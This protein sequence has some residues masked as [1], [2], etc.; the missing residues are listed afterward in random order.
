MACAIASARFRACKTSLLNAVL[1]HLLSA[2]PSAQSSAVRAAVVPSFPTEARTSPTQRLRS[3]SSADA[4][5]PQGAADAN[6][7]DAAA[8]L[9]VTPI[10]L[11]DAWVEGFYGTSARGVNVYSN[12]STPGAPNGYYTT[13]ADDSG[14]LVFANVSDCSSFSDQ[15]M[16]R[17]YGWMPATTSPRPLAE[18][19]YWTIRNDVG[20]AE[21]TNVNDIA[22][23]DV[24]A[25]LYPP[26]GASDTGHVAWIDALPVAFSGSPVESGLLQFVVTV[27]DSTNGFHDNVGGPSTKTDDRYLGNLT[28]GTQCTTD[29][30]CLTLYGSNAACNSES[31]INYSVCSYTGVGRGQMRLYADASG[32]IQG[33]TWSPNEESTYYARPNPL[34]T[35]GGS[36]TGEDIVVGHF[37]R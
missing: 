18:D 9:P 35:Q 1:S 20:F 33:H 32:A 37:H 2:L 17:S 29:T 23:G 27:I 7:P 34:P 15:L 8:A 25:L 5:S 21:V 16:Q 30:Q 3:A 4:S 19:Y 6:P 26:G 11:A 13:W 31:L 22:V 24:I 28:G 14:S 10:S 12:T 36:F